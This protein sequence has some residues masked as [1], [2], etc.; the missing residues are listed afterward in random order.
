MSTKMLEFDKQ[1]E[2]STDR[3]EVSNSETSNEYE[4]AWWSLGQMEEGDGKNWKEERYLYDSEWHGITICHFSDYERAEIERYINRGG[5]TGTQE[6]MKWISFERIA[7]EYQVISVEGWV[8]FENSSSEIGDYE[9]T[10]ISVWFKDLKDHDRFVYS[11][12]NIRTRNKKYILGT[13][14]D[15]DGIHQL[16]KEENYR[17]CSGHR[18]VLT[19]TDSLASTKMTLLKMFLG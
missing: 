17:I 7:D 12:G 9:T 4:I 11:L 5:T 3:P 19:I 13:E 15:I 6:L 10:E 1:R 2:S 8:T 18:S 14:A 16:L